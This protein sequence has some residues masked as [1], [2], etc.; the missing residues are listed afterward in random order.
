M[1]IHP[2][3]S[4]VIVLFLYALAVAQT[5]VASSVTRLLVV[6]T[7]NWNAVD[8][9]LVRYQR[10]GKRWKRVGTPVPIVVGKSGLGWDPALKP[11]QAR[12]GGPVKHEGDGRSPAGV[13]PVLRTFGFS[14]TS[15]PD[16]L[17]L[18]P[19]TECVDDSKSAEYAQVVDRSQV[20][21][22]WSSSEKMRSID[23]YRWGAIVG[24]NVRQPVNGDGSCIFLHIWSGAGHGTAGCTAMPEQDIKA[25]LPWL[26]SGN[27]ALVQMPETEYKQLRQ[28]WGLP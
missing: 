13:F 27:V 2:C 7:P 22:D 17:L 15:L 26:A 6:T 4:V 11:E 1:K 5:P 19:N 12:F 9:T 21:V 23:A 16:Y 8:G 14:Q 10:T 24:Y 25:L 28:P 18:T 3:Q 20:P